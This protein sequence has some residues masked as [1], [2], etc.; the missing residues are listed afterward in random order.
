MAAPTP[1]FSDAIVAVLPAFLKVIGI[2]G[3]VL[4]A[5]IVWFFKRMHS[6]LEMAQA[7]LMDWCDELDRRLDLQERKLDRLLVQHHMTHG[8]APEDIPPD[9]SYVAF[10]QRRE[11]DRRRTRVQRL[12]G[13]DAQES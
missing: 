6:Q 9:E 1:D 10:R 8:A 7:E 11:N 12:E 5:L 3:G 4:F 13:R 2:V